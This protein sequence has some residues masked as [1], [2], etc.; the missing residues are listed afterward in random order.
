MNIAAALISTK[1]STW[2]CEEDD[3]DA[4]DAEVAD[5]DA[6]L[7][8]YDLAAHERTELLA[9]CFNQSWTTPHPPTYTI[10]K[11]KNNRYSN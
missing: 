1:Y 9:S 6:N 10:C 8:V 3:D 7:E 11:G 4:T 2:I 5:E